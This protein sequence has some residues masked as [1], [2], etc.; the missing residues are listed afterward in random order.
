[1]WFGERLDG[2][3]ESVTLHLPAVGWLEWRAGLEPAASHLPTSLSPG[4][5]LIISPA[6]G[7]SSFCLYLASFLSFQIV[8]SLF[9]P[10]VIIKTAHC[11]IFP[12]LSLSSSS[13]FSINLSSHPPHVLVEVHKLSLLLLLLPAPSR[14]LPPPPCVTAALLSLSPTSSVWQPQRDKGRGEGVGQEAAEQPNSVT[15]SAGIKTGCVLWLFAASL[16]PSVRVRGQ[17]VWPDLCGA[18]NGAHVRKSSYRLLE[19]SCYMKHDIE[20][21]VDSKVTLLTLHF[22][23]T[24]ST[25][26]PV[27]TVV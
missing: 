14:P 22:Q 23:V 7:L 18:T 1:M 24:A 10:Y 4:P 25:T 8:R 3:E 6:L 19:A 20:C 27:K 2:P 17:E 11:T 15:V 9:F 5:R 16:S 26:Q 21:R 12:A 13:P